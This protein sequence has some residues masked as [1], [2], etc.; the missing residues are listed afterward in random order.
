MCVC[1]RVQYFHP[2]H[3]ETPAVLFYVEWAHYLEGGTS[4][5]GEEDEECAD[6]PSW[7]FLPYPQGTGSDSNK[8]RETKKIETES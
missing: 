8:E 3:R 7:Q 1:V 2:A 4:V 6:S 5:G